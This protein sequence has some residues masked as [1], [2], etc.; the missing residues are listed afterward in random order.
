MDG[1]APVLDTSA[2]S[3]GSSVGSN[4]SLG[5]LEVDS[6]L[7]IAKPEEK[8]DKSDDSSRSFSEE[9]E[10]EEVEELKESSLTGGS[11]GNVGGAGASWTEG[12]G[13]GSGGGGSEMSWWTSAVEEADNV[14][15]DLDALV[16]KVEEST[17]KT[18]RSSSEKQ[19]QGVVGR[20]KFLL[21]SLLEFIVG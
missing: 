10:E 11:P 20:G 2:L 3:G 21:L 15:D 18:E 13:V 8:S 9:E 6:S 17:P 12:E 1:L 16:N 4:V 19:R 14:G 5:I 7:A